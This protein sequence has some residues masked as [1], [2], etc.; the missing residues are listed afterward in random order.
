MLYQ[1]WSP[2]S[3][4]TNHF[5]SIRR[6][7]WNE[8]LL[9]G[10]LIHPHFCRRKTCWSPI[11]LKMLSPKI[12]RR[13]RPV[14]VSPLYTTHKRPWIQYR[15]LVTTET[16]SQHL[17][18][19]SPH[20]S[21]LLFLAIFL[22]LFSLPGWLLPLIM[23]GCQSLWGPLLSIVLLPLQQHL[24]L[25]VPS[26]Q[27]LQCPALIILWWLGLPRSHEVDTSASLGRYV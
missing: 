27:T 23:A 22:F 21:F 6:Y 17:W 10:L 15:Q 18:L 14:S 5:H 11:C 20:F 25:S 7:D 3:D 19:N 26:S 1:V 16:G 8:H 4:Q 2:T 24:S 9:S 13:R 12:Y